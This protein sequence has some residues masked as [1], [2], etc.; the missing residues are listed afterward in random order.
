MDPEASTLY[1]RLS[2][3][4]GKFFEQRVG[5]LGDQLAQQF[6]DFKHKLASVTVISVI[7]DACAFVCVFG[8]SVI[9][10]LLCFIYLMGHVA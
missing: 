1:K 8:P 4:S 7:N 6:K 3:C 2:K 9:S 5:A 10:S